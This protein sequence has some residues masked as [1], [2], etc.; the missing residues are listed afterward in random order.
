MRVPG[1]FYL[2]DLIMH[3]GALF[4]LSTVTVSA[5]SVRGS[6]PGVRVTWRTTVPSECMT[7][8]T[9]EFRLT[10]IVVGL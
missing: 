4:S 10:S 3:A 6:T 7:P 9:V 5:E 2:P 1:K 8:M